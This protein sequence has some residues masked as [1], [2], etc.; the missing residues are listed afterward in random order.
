MN[1]IY[2]KNLP[3]IHYKYNYTIMYRVKSVTKDDEINDINQKI[4]LHI[5]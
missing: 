1:Y 2:Y 4:K 5:L 3:F